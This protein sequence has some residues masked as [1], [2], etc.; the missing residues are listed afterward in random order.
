M[1]ANQNINIDLITEFLTVSGSS[2]VGGQSVQNICTAT[3]LSK[4][5]VHR[6]INKCPAILQNVVAGRRAPTYYVDHRLL[7]DWKLSNKTGGS[8]KKGLIFKNIDSLFAKKFLKQEPFIILDSL[9]IELKEGAPLAA[10]RAVAAI[11]S[12]SN[13][14]QY[15][16]NAEPLTSE[17]I[18]QCRAD[19]TNLA[20]FGLKLLVYMNSLQMNPAFGNDADFYKLFPVYNPAVGKDES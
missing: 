11:Y 2:P 16:A 14:I 19:I 8:S 10:L 17:E 15:D 18:A 12:K 6:A 7:L 9:G 1:P 5:T 3:G 20:T 13:Q 4:A